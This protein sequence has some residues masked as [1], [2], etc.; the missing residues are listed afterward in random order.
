MRRHS[1]IVLMSSAQR[2]RASGRP[3]GLAG[4]RVL[5][6]YSG[7]EPLLRILVEGRDADE[8]EAIAEELASL[9]DEEIGEQA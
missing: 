4:G 6:R 9:I 2:L 7:T 5:L 8:I 1:S 3:S